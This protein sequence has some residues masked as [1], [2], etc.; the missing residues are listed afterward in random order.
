M[1]NYRLVESCDVPT[2]PVKNSS[3]FI[4]LFSVTSTLIIFLIVFLRCNMKRMKNCV[5]PIIPDPK[6]S[7]HNLF[8]S[9][10][11]YFQEWMKTA[12]SDSHQEV[13]CV[14]DVRN[15][16]PVA[17]Y[18]KETEV[19]P[20]NQSVVNEQEDNV[21]LAFASLQEEASNVCCGNM[22]ITMTESIF[23]QMPIPQILADGQLPLY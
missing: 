17:T 20:G 1:E 3:F 9:H 21:T 19:M 15:D 12:I 4:I 2:P 23:S 11:E 13:E 22:N 7:F 18:V 5:F 16:E 10:N 8:D 14:M 6:N